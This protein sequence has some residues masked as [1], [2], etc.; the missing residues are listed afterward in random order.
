MLRD[1]ILFRI[2]DYFDHLFVQV[3]RHLFLN[4]SGSSIP[5]STRIPKVRVNWPHQLSI[6]SN[7][8]L[9]DNLIFKYDS[10]WKKGPNIVIGSNVF[11][12]N[13]TE[14]NISKKI[15][16]G[17]DCLIASGCK[18]IDHNHGFSDSTTLIRD[19][20]L[21]EEPIIIENNVW[22]GVN[23]LI[24]KG[25]RIGSGSVIGAGSIVSHDIPPKELWCGN[26][27]KLLKKLIK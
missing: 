8:T 1:K 24:L 21:A 25:V 14:F 18:F 3:F 22:F 4:F 7:C 16:I 20:P 19:Q 5:F 11:I 2:K 13:N 12:G 23:C 10:I 17:D 27:A 6:G 15:S 26:P 9:E